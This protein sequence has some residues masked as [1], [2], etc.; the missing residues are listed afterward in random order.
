MPTPGPRT[1]HAQ[2][3]SCGYTPGFPHPPATPFPPKPPHPP[4]PSRNSIWLN[5]RGKGRS[6]GGVGL[7]KPKTPPFRRRGAYSAR[8]AARLRLCDTFIGQHPAPCGGGLDH[9]RRH[10]LN[11]PPGTDRSPYFQCRIM[12]EKSKFGKVPIRLFFFIYFSFSY[13]YAS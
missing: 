4:A 13:I 3:S 11:H 9:T 10:W 2:S 1:L 12:K 6:Y 8:P 5:L 7:G